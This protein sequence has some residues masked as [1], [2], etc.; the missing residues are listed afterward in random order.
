MT[1]DFQKREDLRDLPNTLENAES[2]QVTKK[3]GF[4]L[5]QVEVATATYYERLKN[6]QVASKE[7]RESQLN[8]RISDKQEADLAAQGVLLDQRSP[9]NDVSQ[10]II[11][12]LSTD[13]DNW[14]NWK[15]F[16]YSKFEI[17]A[18]SERGIESIFVSAGLVSL[19]DQY[20]QTQKGKSLCEDHL[21][22]ILAS[23]KAHADSTPGLPI[24]SDEASDVQGLLITA[25]KYNPWAAIEVCDFFLWI[26]EQSR[27]DPNNSLLNE[28][29]QKVKSRHTNSNNR[30]LVLLNNLKNKSTV[31]P[32][33]SRAFTP[34]EKSLVENLKTEILRK[35]TEACARLAPTSPEMVKKQ[36]ASAATLPELLES[37]LGYQN[38]K[39][40]T[41]VAR[42]GENRQLVA[43]LFLCQAIIT[44]LRAHENQ[45]SLP[46]IVPDIP[47]I[48]QSLRVF[49]HR[50]LVGG[51]ARQ[52]DLAESGIPNFE[53]PNVDVTIQPEND[54][55][56]ALFEYISHLGQ[57]ID[58]ADIL[59]GN[60]HDQKLTVLLQDLGISDFSRALQELQSFGQKIAPDSILVSQLPQEIH[61]LYP[62]VS[63]AIDPKSSSAV[64]QLVTGL[65]PYYLSVMVD[66]RHWEFS[67]QVN[68]D[69]FELQSII[70]NKVMDLVMKLTHGQSE[71][72]LLTEIIM[73]RVSE[74]LNGKNQESSS[75]S[76]DL[77]IKQFVAHCR[78]NPE[79]DEFETYEVPGEISSG[80]RDLRTTPGLGGDVLRELVATQKSDQFLAVI[81][82]DIDQI[83]Q[84]YDLFRIKKQSNWRSEIAYRDMSLDDLAAREQYRQR[85]I[86]NT[87]ELVIHPSLVE[88]GSRNE[89]ARNSSSERVQFTTR[90]EDAEKSNFDFE[91]LESLFNIYS[92]SWISD[93]HVEGLS[94]VEARKQKI[95]QLQTWLMEYFTSKIESG[96]LDYQHF[97]DFINQFVPEVG[98]EISEVLFEKIKLLYAVT[99]HLLQKFPYSFDSNHVKNDTATTA[100]ENFWQ[101]KKYLFSLKTTPDTAGMLMSLKD[102]DKL[103]ES[104]SSRTKCQI[105]IDFLKEG[106]TFRIQISDYAFPPASADTQVRSQ[107]PALVN[108]SFYEQ[109]GIMSFG[110]SIDFL[111]SL[112]E[113]GTQDLSWFG[114]ELNGVLA[115]NQDR[116]LPADI[117][118]VK[119]LQ[120]YAQQPDFLLWSSQKAAFPNLDKIH[121]FVD[122]QR[123][124]IDVFNRQDL[125]LVFREVDRLPISTYRDLCINL[126]LQ[127]CDRAVQIPGIHPTDRQ[128]T[129]RR[130]TQQITNLLPTLSPVGLHSYQTSSPESPQIP[131]DPIA[132]SEHYVRDAADSF[133]IA[134]TYAH[135]IMEYLIQETTSKGLDF[136]LSAKSLT[137]T[138]KANPEMVF[139]LLQSRLAFID[140]LPACEMKEV[141]VSYSLVSFHE[142]ASVLPDWSKYQE[143]FQELL[144]K[145]L[146]S[147]ATDQPK[148]KL[149]AF[150]LE[151]KLGGV[152]TSV[153]PESISRVFQNR[154]DYLTFLQNTFPSKSVARD[155]YISL[156]IKAFPLKVDEVTD[157]NDLFFSSEHAAAS[158][159]VLVQ[160]GGLEVLRTKFNRTQPEEIGKILLWLIDDK[161]QVRNLDDF[162]ELLGEKS[163]VIRIDEVIEAPEF[164][165]HLLKL[166]QWTRRILTQSAGES[167]HWKNLPQLRKAS[168]KLLTSRL[169]SPL[170]RAAVAYV[171]Q[172]IPKDELAQMAIRASTPIQVLQVIGSEQ[173][174][175]S[176]IDS[177]SFANSNSKEVF[178]DLVLN[179]QGLLNAP[180]IETASDFIGL[181]EAG[182]LDH[183]MYPFIDQVLEKMI[184]S[185]SDFS[186]SD[187]QFI[188]TLAFAFTS[189]LPSERRAD[190]FF[191]LAQQ[192]KTSKFDGLNQS[193]R[194]SQLLGIVLGSLGL[195]GAKVG[196][197]DELIPKELRSQLTH[198]K[199]DTEPMS[200]LMIADL[201]KQEGLSADYEIVKVVASASTASGVLCRD[202]FGK[203]VFVK[204]LKPDASLNAPADLRAAK[205]TAQVLYQLKQTPANYSGVIDEISRMVEKELSTAQELDNAVHYIETDTDDR[206]IRGALVEGVSSKSESVHRYGAHREIISRPENSSLLFMEF[207]PSEGQ[208]QFFP[209]STIENPKPASSNYARIL[210]IRSKLD[211]NSVYEMLTEDFLYRVFTLHNWHG[212]LHSGNI[213]IGLDENSRS[214]V[215]ASVKKENLRFVDF[216]QVGGIEGEHAD[217]Q[218]AHLGSFLLGLVIKDRE[219]VGKSIMYFLKDN[220]STQVDERELI[221]ALPN[222]LDAV[223]NQDHFL[224][225][226]NDLLSKYPVD[227]NL[228]N[229]M[230]S[231]LTFLPIMRKLPPQKLFSMLNSHIDI[232]ATIP[233]L[234]GKVISALAK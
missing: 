163:D 157:L 102:F 227:S 101:L 145:Y 230:S 61:D 55:Q 114:A 218:I 196:Q 1:S 128:E 176:L 58:V 49:K 139:T 36:I 64:S 149:F 184:F 209:L 29:K 69:P 223:V 123:K 51:V 115:T 208:E 81:A 82:Q 171:V 113:L 85:L 63:G 168:I 83:R 80:L 219:L 41:A 32:N 232:Q 35:Q 76:N 210:E 26:E 44:E 181:Y 65:S 56:R 225:Q 165:E 131:S 159:N 110:A 53:S 143:K 52:V 174:A 6:G 3:P 180:R 5:S 212:D 182:K 28:V 126:L 97:L 183:A 202:P 201:M 38:L 162:I 129:K 92:Y 18:T 60:I 152:G 211:L 191:K 87:Q 160:Q 31:I 194:T 96:Q 166:P 8:R 141:L 203:E 72:T 13:Q 93:A 73:A 185:Q 170:K 42:L 15:T 111:K 177:T 136:V 173:T 77:L 17:D 88:L 37:I 217:E 10:R 213:L 192:L 193:A 140:N 186:Q 199:N 19:L 125:E 229:F 74:M 134:P 54:N 30:R 172:H 78:Y 206:T 75:S 155:P 57:E 222:L 106:G 150:L 11:H 142:D 148:Q 146:I 68:G 156:A 234:K 127:W 224:N 66:S 133:R 197:R 137:D 20:L 105:L 204:V 154:S 99:S 98:D 179:E 67:E 220:I 164:R 47:L 187:Q 130:F 117:D 122:G 23:E 121:L 94:L 104:A 214:Q 233:G 27:K 9:W 90:T 124:N 89:F 86:P 34:I 189:F 24:L 22:F 45:D 178:F 48:E 144:N 215:V 7:K 4:E 21:A 161:Q 14:E 158:K 16:F 100:M 228:V 167:D 151:I 39:E 198:F 43:K 221:N 71:A 120:A 12:N 62:A 200:P 84:D 231:L 175:N 169:P 91:S 103:M 138:E 226:L 119:S 109:Q 153:T 33:Q 46:P 147:F 50:T 195:V 108:S 216:G 190:I 116:Y 207:L 205:L 40:A 135:K 118:A 2:S 112:G 95:G 107:D 25:R 59:S 132:S 188:K 79:L 70:Q